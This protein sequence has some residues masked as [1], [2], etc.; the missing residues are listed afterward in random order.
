MKFIKKTCGWI[1][2]FWSFT[3]YSGMV[4]AGQS[5]GRNI[6][7]VIDD[8]NTMIAG[9]LTLPEKPLTDALVIMLSGSGPQDRDE[10]LDGFRV[11]FHLA[12]HLSEQGIPS[13]RFD[14]R[15]V[16]GSSGNFG[17]STLTD[18]SNDVIRILDYFST[19]AANRFQR[20][21]LLGHSQGGIVAANV[22]VQRDDVEKVI[23]MAAPSVPLIDIVLYQVRQEYSQMQID[24]ALIESGVS[25][26]HRLMWSIQ[27]N[28]D[29]DE[30]LNNFKKTT[31]EVLV[32]SPENQAKPLPELKKQA[33]EQ[34]QEFKI[35][36]ALPSLTSFLYND[37]A[38]NFDDFTVPVLG[39]FG[40]KDLQVTIQ[41]NKD[42]MEKALLQSDVEYEF[43]TFDDA[44]HYFQKADTG[45]RE[46][47]IK[48]EKAF[49]PGFP[50]VIS[51][52]I[53]L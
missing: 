7:L 21:I 29:L 37:P 5:H 41:Q 22:A 50:K 2:L 31:L 20:F 49:V 4:I 42:I 3:A 46:E 48:L 30:A 44:N 16:G 25:A 33:A 15:G 19:Q 35:V 28:K 13:F 47:Y 40:G 23:L 52:W 34:T 26:H 9:E 11:F 45:L 36:Y 51:D 53:L 38:K 12:K 43:V 27:S 18:H 6:E 8:S 17:Q 32:A 14:D 39:L 1:V 10:T 24:S